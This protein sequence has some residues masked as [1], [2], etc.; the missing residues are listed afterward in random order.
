MSFAEKMKEEADR[1]KNAETKVPVENGSDSR[2]ELLKV[3]SEKVIAKSKV[4][5][6]NEPRTR[7]EPHKHAEFDGFSLRLETFSDT[8]RTLATRIESLERPT[9]SPMPTSYEITDTKINAFITWVLH[10]KPND[11]P[12]Q[13]Q[14]LRQTQRYQKKQLYSNVLQL[15]R[16][17]EGK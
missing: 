5:V 4:P 8:L 13:A 14:L 16:M 15:Y 7:R 6:E 11:Y 1:R 10:L 17:F 12:E 9:S 2:L 3:A